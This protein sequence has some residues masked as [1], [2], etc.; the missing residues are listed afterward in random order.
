MQAGQP[1]VQ[2][3]AP[4]APA[5]PEGTGRVKLPEFWPQAPGIWH[6]AILSK[7]SVDRNNNIASLFRT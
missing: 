3:A 6:T 7:Y 1:V 2:Q 4:V 5:A